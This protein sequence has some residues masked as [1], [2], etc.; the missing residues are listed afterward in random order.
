MDYWVNEF[1]VDGYRFDLSKG[2]TQ[3]NSGSNVGAWG[4]YDQSCVNIWNDYNNH[5]QANRAGTYVILEHF[6][7]NSEERVLSDAG[8]MLWGNLNYTYDQ[9]GQGRSGN[10]K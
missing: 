7:D 1:R 3:V 8:M 10:A 2:F 5:M 9:A 4:N 6:A